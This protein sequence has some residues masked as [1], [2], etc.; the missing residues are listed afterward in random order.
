MSAS[1]VAT[2]DC[3]H[4]LFAAQAERTPDRIAVTDGRRELTYRQLDEAADRLAG[5]LRAAGVGPEVLVGL[6]ADRNVDLV[7]AVLGVLK[8]GGGYVPLDPRYPANRLEFV[9]ADCRCPV[10][11]GHRRFADLVP[12]VPFVALDDHT[13]VT[14]AEPAAAAAWPDN[15]AYVIHTSGST[16]TPKGVVVSHANVTRLFAVTR[17]KF[18]VTASDTWTLFHSYAFDFSVWELWGALLHGGRVVVVPYETSR[19]PEA[20]WRLLIEQQVTVLSQTP[21]AFRQL[22]RAAEAAGWPGTALRL[23]VFGGEALEPA[24]LLPWFDRFGDTTP[25]LINMYG[26]T[27]TT[28]HVTVRPLTRADAAGQGSPIGVPLDD[29][30]VGLLDPD[31]HTVPPGEPGEAYVGG[32]GVAGGYLGRPGLTARRFVPDPAGPPGARRYRTGDLAALRDGELAFL[33]RVDDQVQ[34]RGFRVE[35]AEIEAALTALSGVSAAAVVLHHDQDGEAYLAG[36]VVAAPGAEIDP[37]RLRAALAER[38]PA[39]LIPSTV[40]AL[41]ALPLT[42]NGKLDREALRDRQAAHRI[43]PSRADMTGGPADVLAGIW[44]GVLGVER[45]GPDDDFFTLGG[46]SMTAIRVVSQAR[47]EHIA[48][49]VHSLFQHPTIAGLVAAGLDGEV[50]GITSD[51]TDTATGTAED[52]VYPA[53][54][55]QM[56]LIYEY[57]INDDPTL[58]H[59]V[60]A[61]R[62]SGP[63]DEVALR[64]ALDATSAR[65]ELLRTSFDLVGYLEPVQIVHAGAPIPLTVLDA[66]DAADPD[67]ALQRWWAGQWRRPF[68]LTVAPLARCHVLRHPD[69]A[70]HLALS[71]HHSVVDG[72]SFAVVM[73]DLL[74]AYDHELG[75]GAPLAAPAAARYRDFVA[76]ERKA[77]ADPDTAAYWTT[78]LDGYQPTP[79]WADSGAGEEALLTVPVD[80]S[81]TAEVRRLAVQSGVPPKSVYLAAHLWALGELTGTADVLTGLVTNGRP[82]HI[83]AD[84]VVGMF[85]NTLPLRLEL[86]DGSWRSLVSAAFA[87]ERAYLRH[88]HFPPAKLRSVTGFGAPDVLFNYADFRAY[89]VLGGLRAIR[90]HEW[91]FGDRNGFPLSVTVARRPTAPEWDLSVRVGAGHG[92]H[93]LAESASG[94]MLNALRRIVADP[95]GSAG[96]LNRHVAPGG[97]S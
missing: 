63:L 15:T 23:V 14:P 90:A 69:G 49:S 77:A 42:A 44:A 25:R 41:D 4:E 20:F 57:E 70:W 97:A 17:A 34:F 82:E 55:L 1:P 72:W 31:L 13:A 21:S 24:M 33:G 67:E 68:D 9:L 96:R 18:G 73:A 54:F 59:D 81:L 51:A 40:T 28:V 88:R 58:Y 3:L 93:A 87:A 46:D 52:R 50:D 64:R 84:T 91:W 94:L 83:G 80:A 32:A 6:C 78:L 38:L 27:E 5:R 47:E 8:A 89:D 7:V 26:I 53:A 86:P 10:V 19:D 75:E 11:V 85:V 37:R 43:Q 95:D 79:L 62:L 65:H 12:G 92:G 48:I 61:V 16:G 35:P 66:P 39:H 60:S 45:V 30:E 36:F 22:I 2:G 29:L 74:Q 71:V 76:L 56:G